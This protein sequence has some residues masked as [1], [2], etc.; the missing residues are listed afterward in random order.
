MHTEEH[1][2]CIMHNFGVKTLS[3]TFFPSLMK[4][5]YGVTGLGMILGSESP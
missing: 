5:G 4:A 3:E 2:H 1:S